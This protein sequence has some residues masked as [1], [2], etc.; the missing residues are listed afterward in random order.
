MIVHSYCTDANQYFCY[1]ALLSD[2][3]IPSLPSRPA[4]SKVVICV[5]FP[6]HEAVHGFGAWFRLENEFWVHARSCG[7]SSVPM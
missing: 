3:R 2:L 5:G 7:D 6:K 4:S 1:M